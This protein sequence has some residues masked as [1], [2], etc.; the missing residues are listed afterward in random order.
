MDLLPPETLSVA[1]IHRLPTELLRSI[2]LL[3]YIDN[4]TIGWKA[5]WISAHTR[6][7]ALSTPLFWTNVWVFT[8]TGRSFESLSEMLAVQLHRCGSILPLTV[9]W[10]TAIAT[11]DQMSVLL[12]LFIEHKAP[13]NRWTEF[14]L[15]AHTSLP[16]NIPREADLGEF[17]S[18][19]QLAISGI[20]PN[21]FFHYLESTQDLGALEELEFGPPSLSYDE[22]AMAAADDDL[23]S[24]IIGLICGTLTPVYHFPNLKELAVEVCTRQ[25]TP[26]HIPLVTHLEIYFQ[27]LLL[28]NSTFEFPALTILIL[29]CAMGDLRPLTWLSAPSLTFLR[30]EPVSAPI[31]PTY[32]KD[33]PPNTQLKFLTYPNVSCIQVHIPLNL[34]DLG[35]LISHFPAARKMAIPLRIPVIDGLDALLFDLFEDYDP[36]KR[37]GPSQIRHKELETVD[38]LAMDIGPFHKNEWDAAANN[39]LGRFP[40]TK[41]KELTIR[42]IEWD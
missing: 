29:K 23:P 24:N 3:S 4:Y 21:L 35:A 11:E 17:S 27:I 37:A 8:R 13:F 12:G 6:D 1:P 16:L 7:I 19:E 22:L 2:L 41:L 20:R 42:C 32:H 34:A 28:D 10:S 25:L 30:V 31:D 14:R 5:G 40:D 36:N 33:A 38:V 9:L 26:S 39:F 18:L 15:N